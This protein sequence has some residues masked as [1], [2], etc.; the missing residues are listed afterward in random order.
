MKRVTE[1]VT[2]VKLHENL[3]AMTIEVIR[4][5]FNCMKILSLSEIPIWRTFEV[6][7]MVLDAWPLGRVSSTETGRLNKA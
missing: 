1:K 7:V 4:S 3:K 6:V 2:S 5:E